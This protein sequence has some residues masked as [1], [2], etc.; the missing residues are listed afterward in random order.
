[1]I[2]TKKQMFIVIG[3]F[4]LVMLLGT[5]T[6]AFFNYTRT[7]TANTIKVGRISFVSKNEQSINLT[8]LFP[9]DPTETGIMNDSTKVGTYSIEINGD[10]DYVDGIEYL[11]SVVDAN[12]YTNQGQIVPISLDV[13]VTDLGTASP[14]YWTARESKNAT[15]YKKLVGDTLVGDQ[16]LLV[17][18]IKP[19]TT[20]GTA[21]GVDG[22]ITIKAYLDKN[23]ILISDTYDGTESDNMGTTNSQA[24]GKTVL[25]TNEWNALQNTGVS[26]KVK[27]EANE[28]IWVKGSLEEIMKVQNLNTT[29]QEPIRDDQQSPYVTGAN[30]IDFGEVSSDTNGKGVYMRAGTEN[31]SYPIMYYRGD[32]TDNNVL[33]GGYC[34]KT[35]RTTDTGGVKLI[36]NGELSQNKVPLAESDYAIAT[37]TANLV[38]DSTTSTYSK[39]ITGT[40]GSSGSQLEISFTVPAGDGYILEVYGTTSTSGQVSLS[41]SYP[42]GG[43][44]TGNGSGGSFGLTQAI[45]TL[46]S[47]GVVTVRY[48]GNGTSES[49]STLNVRMI[50]R[51]GTL[52]IG[53]DNS[54]RA[55]QLNSTNIV[56]FSGTN[57]Y[58]SPA[59]V[60]YMRGTNVYEHKQKNSSSTFIFGT[61]FTYSNGTYTLTSAENG[62]ATTRH[63]TCFTT[64]ETCDGTEL[65]K[66]YYVYYKRENYYYYIELENG[67]SVEDA[68]AEMQTNTVDST[69]KEKIEDWYEA[70][71]TSYTRKIEDTIYCND[72]S[73]NTQ[74]NGWIA[75]GGELTEYLYFAPYGRAYTTY[76]PSLSCT[77]KNDSFTWKNGNGNQ[78]LE[79]PVGMITSDEIMLAGGKGGRSDGEFYLNTGTYW[80]SLSPSDFKISYDYIGDE[81]RAENFARL[82][83]LDV[84]ITSGLRP[85]VSIKPGQ[86]ITK[87]TGTVT[88]P[89]VIE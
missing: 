75:N 50:K 26:F 78:K 72:R 56:P 38:F 68:L 64:S 43:N 25:T 35:V 12:I 85:V 77:N 27:V 88:D 67:K 60:G 14:N 37:N 87:G 18:Y 47:S 17:G 28:G 7:G 39:E 24:N 52:G 42:G 46:T 80:W 20:S 44:G 32:V 70:N 63:Y 66:I 13:T 6:Y 5:V 65:G 49:P 55:S 73:M 82:E 79:Y 19:N 62:I 3:V 15:I 58:K 53:C 36:Y 74:T 2:K 8:N 30:G 54:G 86:F 59:Y 23:N 57:L 22:S 4:T 1:M 48:Y 31:D 10:T 69:S 40:D 16:M 34:W 51:D 61:G 89:Y 84:H 29:T 81:F 9:I 76:S 11:V 21:E 45:G 33:F 41:I 83:S 71:M